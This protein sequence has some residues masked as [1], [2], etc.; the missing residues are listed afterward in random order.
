L[1]TNGDAKSIYWDGLSVHEY[2]PV[3]GVIPE[4]ELEHR[5]YGDCVTP[6]S[7]AKR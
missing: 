5:E 6:K 4:K 3:F 1:A 2:D 7:I